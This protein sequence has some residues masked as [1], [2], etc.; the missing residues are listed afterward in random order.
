VK[1]IPQQAAAALLT[2]AVSCLIGWSWAI[3][4]RVTILETIVSSNVLRLVDLESGVTGHELAE[5]V[6]RFEAVNSRINSMTD[7]IEKIHHDLERLADAQDALVQ[8]LLN[9]RTGGMR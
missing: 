1:T 9:G 6:A 3:S 7:S 5:T 8:R 4:Q 2:A